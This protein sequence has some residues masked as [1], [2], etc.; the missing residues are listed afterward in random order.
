VERDLWFV[1]HDGGTVSITAGVRDL[2]AGM[3]VLRLHSP[4]AGIPAGT[5]RLA[6]DGY[7]PW[8]QPLDAA[9]VVTPPLR[10]SAAPNPANPTVVLSYALPW[11]AR[12]QL[13]IYDLLGRPVRQWVGSAQDAGTYRQV[14][15]GRDA[16]GVPAASGI[17]HAVLAVEA[18]PHHERSTVR[19]VLLR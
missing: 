11:P 7:G 15:D 13:T 16:R 1:A 18:P 8:A 10:L 9:P 17:Y 12:V 3:E 4:T 2:D 19:L 14:W 6:V 5:C